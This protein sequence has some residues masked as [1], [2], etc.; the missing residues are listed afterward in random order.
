MNLKGLGQYAKFFTAVG[1]QALLY[2]QYT[3]GTN[4]KWVE[5]ATAAAAALAVLAVPNA[6]KAAPAPVVPPPQP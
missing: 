5:L 1:G 4:N 2:A 3:Y 6:P